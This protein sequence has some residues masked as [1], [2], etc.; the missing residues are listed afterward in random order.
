MRR[1]DPGW[2]LHSC[3]SPGFCRSWGS[4]RAHTGDHNKAGATSGARRP[5]RVVPELPSCRC[6]VKL[7][8]RWPG[9]CPVPVPLLERAP[10]VLGP[11]PTCKI[12]IGWDGSVAA[13]AHRYSRA[14]LI[15]PRQRWNE[16]STARIRWGQND[17]DRSYKLARRRWVRPEAG[18]G[19]LARAG[20]RQKVATP[21]SG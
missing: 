7:V 19:T 5:T 12:R 15:V 8:L 20:S 11:T 4:L 21:V 10:W 3:M 13:G 17:G 16:G 6:G 9:L 1:E 18:A 2:P 14:Y